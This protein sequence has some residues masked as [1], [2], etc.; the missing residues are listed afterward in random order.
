M[1]ILFAIFYSVFIV[2]FAYVIT[3]SL[4][5]THSALEMMLWL[6]LIAIQLQF[7]MKC[8]YS[9]ELNYDENFWVNLW[10]VKNHIKKLLSPWIVCEI[11]GFILFHLGEFIYLL[12][13][14]MPHK[15]VN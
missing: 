15:F 11:L 4:Y 7:I 9:V 14:T 5:V 1:F 13:D 2:L 8:Y 10:I 3:S 6:W 12:N